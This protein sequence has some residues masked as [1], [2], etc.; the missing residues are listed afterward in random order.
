MDFRL[1]FETGPPFQI[2]LFF[3]EV[4]HHLSNDFECLM[5]ILGSG[6]SF[7]KVVELKPR[8]LNAI[9]THLTH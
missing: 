9:L 5:R 8:T 2:P 7:L 3:G 4:S 6:N 1:C